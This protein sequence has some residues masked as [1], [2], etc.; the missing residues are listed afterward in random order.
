[1]EGREEL[2][3]SISG[4]RGNMSH[5]TRRAGRVGAGSEGGTRGTDNLSAKERG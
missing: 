1:M 2:E 4:Y 3:I 5:D